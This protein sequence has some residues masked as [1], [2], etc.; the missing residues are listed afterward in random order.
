MFTKGELAQAY[1]PGIDPRSAVNRLM[2]WVKRNAELMQDLQATGY[3]AT[4][5]YFSPRQVEILVAYLGEPE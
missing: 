4:Q 2:A 5:K 1:L 3:Y